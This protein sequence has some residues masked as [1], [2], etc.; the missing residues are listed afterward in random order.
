MTGRKSPNLG[1]ASLIVVSIVGGASLASC[2]GVA[3]RTSDNAA[4][5][6]KM[7]QQAAHEQFGPALRLARAARANGDLASAI[8]LYSSVVAI[9]PAD[10]AI[11]LE[12]GD[13]LVDA[14]SMDDAIDA[15][16]RVEPK[17]TSW[18]GSQLGLQQAYLKLGQPQKALQFADVAMAIAPQDHRVLV[19]RGVTLDML[20]RHAQAQE[21]Y[22][23]ILAS[24]PHNVA[25]RNDLALS[26]AM[27]RHF[28][29][30]VDIMTSMA[31]SSTATPRIRENLA[32]I[33]G[34]AGDA[35][36]AGA[37]SRVDLD[38]A[39]TDGNLRFFELARSAEEH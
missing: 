15:Y 28:A 34:L 6:A 10:P 8:N 25:A 4:A 5:R 23:A 16:R 36:H 18:L 17:S 27:T 2:A 12:L 19:S 11:L 14:G 22:R 30:A 26:L 29:E 9:Q 20:G 37:L 38:A 35:A 33:Y 13:T 31:R 3:T 21:S 7:T 39:T 24:D 32:L 1:A